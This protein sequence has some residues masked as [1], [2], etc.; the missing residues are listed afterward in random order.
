MPATGVSTAEVPN[1]DNF[2]D[3]VDSDDELEGVSTMGDGKAVLCKVNGANPNEPGKGGDDILRCNVEALRRQGMM[4]QGCIVRGYLSALVRPFYDLGVRRVGTDVWTTW[5][6][7]RS[8][9]SVEALCDGTQS[10]VDWKKDRVIFVPVFVGDRSGGHFSL[11]VIDRTQYN[12]GIFV[13]FDSYP[14]IGNQTAN[15]LKQELPKWPFW[16]EGQSV[17]MSQVGRGQVQAPGS[18]DCGILTCLYACAYLLALHR[19]KFFKQNNLS[20]ESLKYMVILEMASADKM[21]LLGRFGRA[22]IE[23]AIFKDHVEFTDKAVAKGIK[24]SLCFT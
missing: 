2:F 21:A 18:N 14:A 15:Q 1:G 24:M 13:Y 3:L 4:V 19:S 11:L 5:L 23:T 20:K 12:P 22:H 7:T 8:W 9:A 17:F 6:A 16:V 10:G